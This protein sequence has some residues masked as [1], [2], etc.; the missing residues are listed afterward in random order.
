[1]L[2]TVCVRMQLVHAL[3]FT[4]LWL[5]AHRIVITK[6]V[7]VQQVLASLNCGCVRIANCDHHKVLCGHAWQGRD[8]PRR[9]VQP[10]EKVMAKQR[11]D[12]HCVRRPCEHIFSTLGNQARQCNGIV[13]ATPSL[14]VSMSLTAQSVHWGTQLTCPYLN[15]NGNTQTV[16]QRWCT[17]PME[18]KSVSEEQFQLQFQFQQLGTWKHPFPSQLATR[19]LKTLVTSPDPKGH[20]VRCVWCTGSSLLPSVL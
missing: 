5:W 12:D 18:K 1:M 14:L 2:I 11:T 8:G 7:P 4:K 15:K 9:L 13:C 17:L 16:L 19:K 20:A 6:S 3:H 10:V